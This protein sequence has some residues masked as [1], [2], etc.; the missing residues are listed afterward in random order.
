MSAIR[1]TMIYILSVLIYHLL[2]ITRYIARYSMTDFCR[3]TEPFFRNHHVLYLPNS[4]RTVKLA[5]YHSISHNTVHIICSVEDK[6]WIY[7]ARYSI[8]PDIRYILVFD[9]L[10]QLNQSRYCIT[11]LMYHD[12]AIYRYIVASLSAIAE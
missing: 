11:R 8:F 5:Y 6:T 10:I 9:I 2:C 3:W 1:D 12:M 4:Y 7:Q